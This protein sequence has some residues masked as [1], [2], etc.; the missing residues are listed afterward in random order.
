MVDLQQKRS[1]GGKIADRGRQ[2]AD[3]SSGEGAK[4]DTVFAVNIC[5]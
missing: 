4:W 5:D 2:E 3:Q 1:G